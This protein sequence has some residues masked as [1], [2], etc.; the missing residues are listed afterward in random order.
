MLV[1]TNAR[2]RAPS[3]ARI[4]Q[5]PRPPQA[6]PAR[7]VSR[8]T[9]PHEARRDPA[10]HRRLAHLPRGRAPAHRQPQDHPEPRVSAQAAPRAAAYRPSPSPPRSP[11][12]GQC[13]TSRSACARPRQVENT[14]CR[15]WCAVP[16]DV[17]RWHGTGRRGP[18]TR[19][20]EKEFAARSR[21][22]RLVRLR[23]ELA[24]ATATGSAPGLV[25]PMSAAQVQ[26]LSAMAQSV[27][28]SP[29]PSRPGQPRRAEGRGPI[30]RL[31]V[32]RPGLPHRHTE[33]GKMTLGEL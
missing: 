3:R 25:H 21:L 22:A 27:D 11:T 12:T 24:S 28:S 7:A 8:R 9:A 32:H 6:S 29:R 2:K 10:P 16:P 18:Y 17:S 31:H 33:T 23:A 19:A 14:H 5:V 30:G 13:S 1:S 20:R 26:P 15:L 4:E